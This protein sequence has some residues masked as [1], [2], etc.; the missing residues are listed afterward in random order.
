M[1]AVI[2]PTNLDTIAD[3]IIV[4]LADTLPPYT[5]LYSD[6]SLLSTNGETVV[7]FNDDVVQRSYYVV[8]RHRN[9]LETWSATPLAIRGSG[10]IYDFTQSAN[11]SYGNNACEVSP[12]KWGIWS[13]DV[14]Q[15]GV[16]DGVD[17]TRIEN[18]TKVFSVGYL[19][20]D[21]TGDHLV[22]STDYSLVDTN[23]GLLIYRMKP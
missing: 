19:P 13:G 16:I 10:A 17:L 5:I 18:S 8:I 1:I 15:D 20:E 12:G 21:L 4:M 14:N 2:D 6:T 11:H 23:S 22:E 9:H 7:H 3:S